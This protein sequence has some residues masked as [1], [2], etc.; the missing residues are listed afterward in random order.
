MID[1]NGK[2]SKLMVGQTKVFREKLDELHMKS[3]GQ[4]VTGPQKFGDHLLQSWP[5]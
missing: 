1:T 2:L 4:N 5:F 3:L